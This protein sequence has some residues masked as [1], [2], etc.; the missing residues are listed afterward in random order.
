MPEIVKQILF[1]R[2]MAAFFSLAVCLLF[3]KIILTVYDRLSKKTKLDLVVIKLLR[4]AVKVLLL[5]L[6]LIVSLS[7][8]GVPV[9]SLVATLSV[10]GVAFSLAVQGFLSNVFGGIQVVSNKPFSVGDYVDAGGESGTVCEVGLFY[11]KLNTPDKK[12]IQIPNSTIASSNITNYSSAEH[13]RVDLSVFLAYENDV[14]AVREVLKDL[15]LSHP[16]TLKEGEL[17]PVSHASEYRDGGILYV[18]RA[19]CKTADYWTVYFDVLD[20]LKPTLDR[21]G[22]R[23]GLPQMRLRSENRPQ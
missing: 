1:S 5:S 23:L 12:V 8:L 3:V 13:R 16:L 2:Y 14:A 21:H 6:S 10:V 7:V 4:T 17:A 15:L 22:I 9:S 19:W 11:T 20:S 18:A